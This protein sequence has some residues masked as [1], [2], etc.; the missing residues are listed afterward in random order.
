MAKLFYRYKFLIIILILI[1][2]SYSSKLAILIFCIFFQTGSIIEIIK[3]VR[4]SKKIRNG[5]YTIG[6]LIEFRK[7]RGHEEDIHNYE[8][9]IEF[10][11]PGREEKYQKKYKFSTLT[12]PVLLKEYKIWVDK[13]DPNNSIVV[14]YFNSYWQFSIFFLFIIFLGLFYV[15]FILVRQLWEMR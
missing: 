11:L 2:F 4:K 13:E 10:S 12:K 5:P 1:V 15:D 9:V 14:D 7:I 6:Q 3:Q 8:G